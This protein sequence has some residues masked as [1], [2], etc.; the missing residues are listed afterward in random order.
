M[1]KITIITPPEYELQIVEAIGNTGVTQFKHVTGTEYEAL[2]GIEQKFDWNNLYNKIHSRVIELEKVGGFQVKPTKP[3]QNELKQFTQ[4]PNRVVDELTSDHYLSVSTGIL[5]EAMSL[6][7]LSI[8]LPR[9]FTSGVCISNHF[10]L[11]PYY[12]GIHKVAG[13]ENGR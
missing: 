8:Y 7:L 3:E 1:K 9:E 2:K 10:H 5:E 12:Q 13:L 4:N 6:R 11:C